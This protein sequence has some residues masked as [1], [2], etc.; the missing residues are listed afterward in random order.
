[1]DSYSHISSRQLFF[2]ADT[3]FSNPKLEAEA[4]RRRRFIGLLDSVPQ[5]STL[6]LL[7][8]IFDFYFEYGSVVLKCYFDILHALRRSVDR[9]V[10]IHFLGGNHDYWVGT[11]LSEEIGIVL[12]GGDDIFLESQGRR[13]CCSHGDLV[14][15]DDGNYRTIRAIIRNRHVVKVARLL[16]PDLMKAIATRV[17][18]GSR[19]REHD[20]CATAT[21]LGEMAPREFFSKGNDVFIIGHVH[22]PFHRVYDG[23]DFMIVGDWIQGCTY[24]KLE[25]GKLSLEDAGV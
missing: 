11:F 14:Q 3:H 24:G 25:D 22:Y 10:A 6:F 18:N 5:G 21:R 2:L 12:H 23:K 9:G 4:G 8:D 7:G 1:M 20:L 17:S 16:H 13:I 15:P 19:K